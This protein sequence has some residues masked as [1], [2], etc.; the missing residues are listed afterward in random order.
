MNFRDVLPGVA[1]ALL[2]AGTLQLAA[3]PPV[4]EWIWHDHQAGETA[5]RL[6][7][8]EIVYLRKT[9]TVPSAPARA[10]LKVC[11]DDEATVFL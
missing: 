9:F 4:P 3:A 5:P 10:E 6:G 1:A 2:S 11:G 7:Q 8:S